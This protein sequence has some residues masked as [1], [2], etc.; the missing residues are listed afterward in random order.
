MKPLVKPL[1]I[2]LYLLCAAGSVADRVVSLGL[3]PG[4]VVYAGLFVLLAAALVATAAVPNPAVRIGYALVLAAAAAF[5]GAFE[6][7][8]DGPL[9]YESF[10][11]MLGSTDSTGDALAQHWRPLAL[12]AAPAL[13]LFA[14][15]A[16]PPR[17]DRPGRQWPLAAA[18]PAAV[19]LLAAIFYVRG[20]DGGRALP[21]AF[22]PLAY[23]L[24]AG[25]EAA[26]EGIGPRQAVALAPA[27]PAAA[28]RDIVLVVDESVA[29]HYLDINRAE[30]V[31]SGLAEP[32]DGVAVRNYG[33]AA[34]MSH[35]SLGTNLT[36]RY[37]GTRGDYQRINAVMPSIWDYARRAGF[38][39]VLVDAQRT[40]GKASVELARGE[41]DEVELVQFERVPVR[42]RDIAAADALAA[43]SR[44]GRADFVVLNKVGAHFP[45]HDKYPDALMRYGPVL[46]RGRFLD[47][48]DTGS[49]DGFGGQ[50]EDWRRYRNAYRNTLLW[51][52]GGFFDRLFARADLART[53]LVYTSDHGQDLHEDARP[54]YTTH[55][56]NP[57][58][59]AQGA[60]PLV[61]IEGKTVRSLD[62][63]VR[64]DRASHY[65][66]FPTLLALMGYRA[67]QVE[68]L[69]GRSLA[70]PLED[71]MT[72]NARFYARLGKEPDWVKVEP[73]K[74]KPLAPEAD[75][76]R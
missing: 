42:D 63:Q 37:G 24:L 27:R 34:A 43:L 29:G 60:V 75:A 20:G 7:V 22:P 70:Q 19:L 48:S 11:V 49:R 59:P 69:Y 23:A 32:R 53:T 15:V 8:N 5:A 56:T 44:N 54:G 36:L 58:L 4:L 12:G 38:R 17:Q 61:V 33:I 55:C 39:P 16:W 57:P 10:L 65:A 51:N 52:V 1:L 72:F 68:P 25:Y 13:L 26:G 3:S 71:P 2:A 47:V 74:L 9:L 31:R 73:E 35:C 76:E 62:W 21:S 67:E 28:G 18:A 40:G 50:A 30:G 64:R 46:P 66:V 14:G 45:V 6:R 41:L